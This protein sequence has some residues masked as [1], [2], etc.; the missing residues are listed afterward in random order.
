MKQRDALEKVLQE[1]N[2]APFRGE[3]MFGR[4]GISYLLTIAKIT[5]LADLLV[6]IGYRE[7][8]TIEHGSDY[9]REALKYYLE[10]KFYVPGGFREYLFR[11]E[12]RILLLFVI[13]GGDNGT[14]KEWVV[15]AGG[16]RTKNYYSP[17]E[18][19]EAIT[20]GLEIQGY[21]ENDFAFQ[22]ISFLSMMKLMAIYRKSLEGLEVFKK[23]VTALGHSVSIDDIIKHVSPYLMGDTHDGK[24]ELEILPRSIRTVI[25]AIRYHGNYSCLVH[26][27]DSIPF[28]RDHARELFISM[29]GKDVPP[30]L[31]MIFQ[32]CFFETPALNDVLHEFIPE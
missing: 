14:I 21:V 16:G 19:P 3:N 22:A 28:T 31:W 11:F 5:D 12:D 20:H 25:S 17:A 32:D 24:I 30:E 13:L 10:P 7:S 23:E 1:K 9:Y 8:D 15:E 4:E 2:Y 29:D 26:L 6:N 18:K 27:R